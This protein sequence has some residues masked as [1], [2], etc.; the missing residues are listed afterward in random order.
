M[1]TQELRAVFQAFPSFVLLCIVCF[2][3]S[4]SLTE[5]LLEL[6]P[7]LVSRGWGRLGADLF[8]YFC[9][10]FWPRCPTLK[11]LQCEGSAGVGGGGGVWRPGA[12]PLPAVL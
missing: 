6:P 9:L 2:F 4:E 1:D 5:C 11:L 10:F 3:F 8:V 12:W 7:A